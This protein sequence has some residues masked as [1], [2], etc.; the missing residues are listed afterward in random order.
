M[1]MLPSLPLLVAMLLLFTLRVK[2]QWVMHL[3]GSATGDSVTRSAK[4]QTGERLP[5]LC[6]GKGIGIE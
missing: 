1:P 3:A 6:A 4:K 2:L 5:A